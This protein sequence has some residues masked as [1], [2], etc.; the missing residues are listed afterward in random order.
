LNLSIIFCSGRLAQRETIMSPR[1]GRVMLT[2]FLVSLICCTACHPVGAESYTTI[3]VSTLGGGTLGLFPKTNSRGEVAW[4][5]NYYDS[6]GLYLSSH[7]QVNPLTDNPDINDFDINDL[8]QVVWS[9]RTSNGYNLFL[10]KNGVTIPITTDGNNNF[11]ASFNNKGDFVWSSYDGNKAR[12]KQYSAATGTISTVW[13]CPSYSELNTMYIYPTINDLGQVAWIN[14]TIDNKDNIYFYDGVANIIHTS[15]SFYSSYPYHEPLYSLNNKGDLILSASDGIWLKKNGAAAQKIASP[16][17]R[18]Y[19][20]RINDNGLVVYVGDNADYSPA[21]YLY[22]SAGLQKISDNGVCPQINNRGQVIWTNNQGIY[23]YSPDS[24]R[25]IVTY[26][27]YGSLRPSLND[28]GRLAWQGNWSG[29]GV[30]LS[31]PTTSMPWLQF[32]LLEV[33]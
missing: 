23:L 33:H 14:Y 6:P 21:I 13:T 8:G 24:L 3:Q 27:N 5:G 15:D 25:P 30:F 1:F 32:L 16:Q 29:D 11:E 9:A 22:G 28:H 18:D 7:G 19:R 10:Y 31:Q 4:S 12:I 2:I 26:G 17:N 20:P